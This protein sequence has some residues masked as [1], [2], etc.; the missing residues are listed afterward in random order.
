MQACGGGGDPTTLERISRMN[1]VTM[2]LG[3]VK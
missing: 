1:V 3:M 2:L